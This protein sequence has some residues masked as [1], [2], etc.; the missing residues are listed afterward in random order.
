MTKLLVGFILGLCMAIAMPL[1]AADHEHG[2]GGN[3]HEERGGHEEGH[4]DYNHH[5]WDHHDH[6][7]GHGGYIYP[8]SA[9]APPYSNGH[10]AGDEWCDWSGRNCSIIPYWGR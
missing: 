4:H 9:W 8:D 5:E 1:F 10:R 2:H 7:R 3:H 6:D